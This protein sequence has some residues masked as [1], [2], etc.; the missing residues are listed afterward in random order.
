MR[1]FDLYLLRFYYYTPNLN[2]GFQ[3]VLFRNDF[4][5]RIKIFTLRKSYYFSYDFLDKG[6]FLR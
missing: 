1:I 2:K 3:S 4:P 6:C 5:M